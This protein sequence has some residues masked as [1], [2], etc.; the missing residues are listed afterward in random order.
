MKDAIEHPSRDVSRIV[1]PPGSFVH[2]QEK[3][4]KRWPAAQKFIQERQLNE[5]FA[6]GT[7]DFGIILQGGMYNT[8]VRSLELLGLSNAFGD[9]QVPLYVLNV[10]YPL[11][12][13]EVKRFCP[14]NARY[15]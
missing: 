8:T 9:S 4:Q 13:E 3:V 2:E 7:Q 1:L 5:F 14:A 6:D 10:T 12:D 15:W 11:V